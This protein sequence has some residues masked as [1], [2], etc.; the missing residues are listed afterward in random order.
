MKLFSDLK[1]EPFLSTFYFPTHNS[2]DFRLVST[3]LFF[4]VI[5]VEFLTLFSKLP[6]DILP[7]EEAQN[8][9]HFCQTSDRL[10]TPEK[11]LFKSFITTSF[12]NEC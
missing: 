3:E 8:F 10:V 2:N 5:V 6:N 7:S 12:F 1:F 9:F 11:R 4:V